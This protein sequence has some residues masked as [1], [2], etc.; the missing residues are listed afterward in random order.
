M[1]IQSFNFSFPVTYCILVWN[2]EREVVDRL[3]ET[4]FCAELYFFS[5]FFFFFQFFPYMYLCVYAIKDLIEE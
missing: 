5:L 1:F 4:A 3:G 2:F